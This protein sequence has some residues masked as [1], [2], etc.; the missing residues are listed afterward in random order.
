[1]NKRI[2]KLRESQSMTRA[3]FGEKIG[4]SGDVINNIERGRVKEKEH[5][6]MLICQTFGVNEEW[7]RTGKGEMFLTEDLESDLAKLTVNLLDEP[8]DSFKNR[9]V[10]MLANMS[11]DDWIALESFVDRLSKKE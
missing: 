8:A 7:L 1:M 11:E 5:M 10:S 9:L 6:V 2:K 3:A 4:V